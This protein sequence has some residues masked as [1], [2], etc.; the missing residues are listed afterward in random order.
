[1]CAL[2]KVICSFYSKSNNSSERKCAQDSLW[3]CIN[4]GPL[5][6][7][8]LFESL[9]SLVIPSDKQDNEPN[10]TILKFMLLQSKLHTTTSMDY[11]LRPQ[12]LGPFN[13]TS[14]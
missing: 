2:Y 9:A 5:K 7:V 10:Y 1:L 6:N 13:E 14:N 12:E 3:I 4:V 11:R 8:E